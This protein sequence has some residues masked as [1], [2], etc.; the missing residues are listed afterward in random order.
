MART[1]VLNQRIV[2]R[3]AKDIEKIWDL[4]TKKVPEDPSDPIKN[5][6]LTLKSIDGLILRVPEGEWD[7]AVVWNVVWFYGVNDQQIYRRLYYDRYPYDTAW[8]VN[9]QVV[10]IPV[11][12]THLDFL[13]RVNKPLDGEESPNL[14]DAGLWKLRKSLSLKQYYCWPDWEPYKWVR[15]NPVIS[16]ESSVE[17]QGFLDGRFMAPSS[18]FY[19]LGGT[20]RSLLCAPIVPLD[21]DWNVF[22]I[23]KWGI[24]QEAEVRFLE[25]CANVD[26]DILED[27]ADPLLVEGLGNEV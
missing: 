4:L 26:L 12:F 11:V 5:S 2:L 15:Q 14:R 16:P 21:I 23:R 6:L 8:V 9:V 10:K 3:D 7:L 25:S 19:K 27:S 13:S 20:D 1:R 24:F 22:C 18:R 17:V